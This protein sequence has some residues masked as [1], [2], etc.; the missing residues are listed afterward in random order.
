[1]PR[2][3]PLRWMSAA[4]A[5]IRGGVV[6]V[7]LLGVLFGL[8]GC[9]TSALNPVATSGFP[10]STSVRATALTTTSGNPV[11]FLDEAALRAAQQVVHGYLIAVRNDD[12]GAFAEILAPPADQDAAGLLQ[13]ERARL[14]VAGEK[15]FLL[16]LLRPL[17]WA[18]DE[19]L[20]E[21]SGTIPG[22]IDAW[23]RARPSERA[24][25]ETTMMDGSVRLFRVEHAAGSGKWLAVPTG[26]GVTNQ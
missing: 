14:Q 24:A 3:I 6:V 19:Y 5:Q 9:G 20:L 22:E 13:E 10:S 25:M 21:P 4:F 26:S 2:K 1:M 12:L 15:A 8:S 23:I 17:V 18:G 16:R 7:L 11:P